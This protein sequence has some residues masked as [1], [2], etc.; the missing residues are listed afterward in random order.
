MQGIT[1]SLAVLFGGQGRKGREGGATDGA[2]GELAALGLRVKV[3][4]SDGNCFFY[5]LCDQLEVRDAACLPRRGAASPL[6]TEKA[7]RVL[8]PRAHS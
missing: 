3:V 8:C 5:A 1:D 6:L 7:V 2:A 4:P